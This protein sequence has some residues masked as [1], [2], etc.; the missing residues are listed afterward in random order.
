MLL[1]TAIS[2]YS[3]GPKQFGEARQE[4]WYKIQ[5]EAVQAVYKMFTSYCLNNSESF[6]L[7][8]I[9]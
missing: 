2:W 3:F 6:P 4:G 8:R 7:F 9:I 5:F 1:Y